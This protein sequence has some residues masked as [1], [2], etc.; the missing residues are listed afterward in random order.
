MI[1]TSTANGLMQRRKKCVTCVS[2][3][4][5]GSTS[6]KTRLSHG[7]STCSFFRLKSSASLDGSPNSEMSLAS[8]SLRSDMHSRKAS[9]HM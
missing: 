1:V 2:T 4:R 6:K 8:A 9:F 3:L 7:L 5:T